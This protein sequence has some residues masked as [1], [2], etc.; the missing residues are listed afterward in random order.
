MPDPQTTKEYIN[1]GV[2]FVVNPKYHIFT[3]KPKWWQ[4]WKKPYEYDT[5]KEI[6][7]AVKLSQARIEKE[8][9]ERL[10]TMTTKPYYQT[11]FEFERRVH[12]IQNTIR[13]N[14]EMPPLAFNERYTDYYSWYNA[15]GRAL[16]E[17]TDETR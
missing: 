14:H 11:G 17:R 12:E 13:A 1:Y 16:N 4:F 9:S 10:Y 2:T 7:K 3:I 15:M 5:I 8:L 6:E